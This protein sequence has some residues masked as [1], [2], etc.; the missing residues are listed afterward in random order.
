MITI[1][2]DQGMLTSNQRLQSSVLH[3]SRNVDIKSTTT[4]ISITMI[5]EWWHQINDYNHHWSRNVDI[6]STITII[7]D[8]GMLTSNQR[9]QSSVIHWSRNVDIKSTITIISITLIKEC[10]HQINDY[11]H[12]YYTDQGMLTWNQLLQS[13]IL[14]LLQW[15]RWS[16]EQLFQKILL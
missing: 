9:L 6:K 1:I 7:I 11:N 14:L 2:I 12:Q 16:P 10:W 4:I 3:W 5:K 8:Q 13:S 15:H